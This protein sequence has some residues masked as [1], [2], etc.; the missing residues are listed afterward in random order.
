MSVDG[1][2]NLCR[3]PQVHLVRGL[4]VIGE[5]MHEVELTKDEFD[6]AC[7]VRDAQE[8]DLGGLNQSQ[9]PEDIYQSLKQKGVIE[10][11]PMPWLQ[12]TDRQN[13]GEATVS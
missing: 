11:I 12:A 13:Y 1:L 8:N 6:V 7:M 2:M 5:G 4:A 10:R 9:L 3:N